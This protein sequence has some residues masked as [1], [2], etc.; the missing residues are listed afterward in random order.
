[1]SQYRIDTIVE[2]SIYFQ[3]NCAAMSSNILNE[4]RFLHEIIPILTKKKKLKI[5]IKS[6]KVSRLTE[7]EIMTV[8]TQITMHR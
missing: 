4:S 3:Q 6:I 7:F 5:S 2:H 1:M 8:V